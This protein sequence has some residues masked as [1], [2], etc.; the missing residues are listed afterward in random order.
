[1]VMHLWKR[2]NLMLTFACVNILGICPE[3]GCRAEKTVWP[4]AK[5]ISLGFAMPRPEEK[6]EN[7]LCKIH[8]M[9]HEP[10][11]CQDKAAASGRSEGSQSD[12]P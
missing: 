1:M 2:T 4:S 5:V 10:Q 8:Q 11:N 6:K 3:G 7:E 12:R 9:L